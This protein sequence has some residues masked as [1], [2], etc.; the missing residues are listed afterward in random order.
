MSNL[1]AFRKG[2]TT[3][4]FRPGI[5]GVVEK[6]KN[7]LIN[8][9]PVGSEHL[10]RGLAMEGFDHMGKDLQM[11]VG[12]AIETLNVSIE[13]M[14]TDLNGVFGKDYLPGGDAQ[15]IA[16]VIAGIGAAA[17]GTFVQRKSIS[18]E[19][20][21]GSA[22][23]HSFITAYNS[24]QT[25]DRL[26]LEAYDE[27]DNKSVV[28]YSI[29]YNLQAARQDAFGEAFFPTVVVTPDQVG[30]SISVNLIQVYSEI[31]R[32]TSG[33]II[34]NFEKKNIIQAVIDPTILENDQTKIYP[35]YATESAPMFVA[36][37]LVP[38]KNV[39]VGTETVETGPLAIGATFDLLGLSQTDALLQTG[40][41]DS[42]DA[43]DTAVSLENIYITVQNT[44]GT[45]KEVLSF[46]VLR[47]PTANFIN[48]AQGLDRMMN[49]NFMTRSLKIDSTIKK[50]DGT[51]SALLTTLVNGGYTV[52]LGLNM[53]GN[54]N[55]QLGE[56]NVFAGAITV[57]SVQDNTGAQLSLT[58]GNGLAMVAL[59][60]GASVVGYDLDARRSN[61]NRR[62]RGQ[63]LD[64]SQYTQVYQVPLLAPITVPRPM[65]AG[66]QNDA[67][68]LAAL[69]TTTNIRT[70]NAAVTEL[71]N[72]AGQLSAYVSS[73]TEDN[74]IVN[75]DNNVIPEVLG[76][77]RFLVQPYYSRQTL[78]VLE[79][80]DS[81]TST[82]RFA[83][84]Q[85]A[86]INK[87]RD[88]A[89]RM[90]RDS[91][92]KAAAD[93]LNGGVAPAPTLLIG[94][95]PVIAR[96]IMV[97]GDLRTAGITFDVKVVDT[98]NINMKDT[99]VLAFGT[100]AA[101]DGTPDPLHFGNMA[102]KPE[103]TIVLP[104]HRNGANSKELTVCPS[105]RHFGNC[106]IMS[107]L[108]IENIQ[109]VIDNKVALAVN[110]TTTAVSS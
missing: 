31:R 11:E 90:Y 56:T 4:V 89:Y 77:A 69:I 16:A 28:A 42:T 58:A 64:I 59:F 23:D 17:P 85:N 108:D 20:L 99:I 67:S 62:E 66:S 86:I 5:G 101:M 41:L 24:A 54:I 95:D 61:L 9:G 102:W 18:F 109:A 37:G 39:V 79:V 43:I 92:Y 2:R 55:L 50:Y 60:A 33:Q 13:N 6:L 44:A 110:A 104:L 19:S 78:N 21:G 76:A 48:A 52:R 94:T 70:S 32:N 83:D 25:R 103:L 80:I 40:I 71:F 30:Y 10:S 63:L 81:L 53:G 97:D 3:E 27:R 22:K 36:Q 35:I 47:S 46:P 68:D 88:V 91:G 98:L 82:Q 105:F 100:K 93:A 87:I 34:K 7:S 12:E 1:S 73:V 38:F 26:S 51:T 72:I 45:T 75:F 74:G 84:I 15:Q 57:I 106:P 49:L 8:S 96:Y 14:I 29:A 65:T 107:I